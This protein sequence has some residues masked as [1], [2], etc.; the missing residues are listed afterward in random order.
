[1]ALLNISEKDNKA[2]ALLHEFIVN[3][4]P[5]VTPEVVKLHIDYSE[6]NRPNDL[7]K[8]YERLLMSA[9][10]AQMKRN[11]IGRISELR[12][13]L[14]DYNPFT[15]LER[16]QE[17]HMELLNYIVKNVKA[18]SDLRTNKNSI[19]PGYCRTI[20]DGASFLSRF[21]RV[22]E[23]HRFV[24]FFHDNSLALP[25]LPMLISRE[26]YGFGFALACDFLKE[27]GYQNYAKPDV[28]LKRILPALGLS[29][30]SDDYD[31]FKA[32]IR[33]AANTNNKPYAIDKLF[34][35]IGSGKFYRSKFEIGNHGKQFIEWAK[36]QLE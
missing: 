22:D 10:N 36:P 23:F 24:C 15:V 33:I 27:I 32:I 28:H 1:M 7:S 18:S 4:D 35:L 2:Y 14:C 25:A 16:Y 3:V 26:I 19:W 20:I 5:R 34:W 17:K 11:V 21:N 30:S 9:S 8:I 12:E 31:V 6:M 29:K 13:A